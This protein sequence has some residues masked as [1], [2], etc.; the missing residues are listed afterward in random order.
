MNDNPALGFLDFFR[1]PEQVI[2]DLYTDQLGASVGGDDNARKSQNLF[3]DAF[4]HHVD[5]FLDAAPELVL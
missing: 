5:V 1:R 2:S 3:S 4:G